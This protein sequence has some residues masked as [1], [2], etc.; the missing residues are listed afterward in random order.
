MAA[1][2][3]ALAL[4]GCGLVEE[5]DPVAV[6]EEEADVNGPDF[7]VAGSFLT[8]VTTVRDLIPDAGPD[9]WRELPD[10]APAVLCYLDG[11]VPQAPP[12]GEP[13][14]RSV[15]AVAGDHAQLIIA[16]YREELRVRAP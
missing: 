6:C 16:G 5:V 10:E 3:L 15:V 8:T 14:D 2:V 13:F 1:V 9:A 7:R 4:S 11:P 12:D